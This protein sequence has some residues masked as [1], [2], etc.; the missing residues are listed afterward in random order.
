[1]STSSFLVSG[2]SASTTAHACRSVIVADWSESNL[3]ARETSFDVTIASPTTT[4][5]QTR[6]PRGTQFGQLFKL[7]KDATVKA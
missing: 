2:P 4:R 7:P 5:A 6:I 1:M 3:R